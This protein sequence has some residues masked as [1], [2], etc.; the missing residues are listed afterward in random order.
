MKRHACRDAWAKRTRVPV[1]VP[2]CA[3][4]FA[5]GGCQRSRAA[6]NLPSIALIRLIQKRYRACAAFSHLTPAGGAWARP[7]TAPM[8][9]GHCFGG[10]SRRPIGALPYFL[11]AQGFFAAHGFFA[12]QGFALV[13]ALFLAEQ[14]LQPANATAGM[15]STAPIRPADRIAERTRV[16][17]GFFMVLLLG[18]NGRTGMATPCVD[19][20]LDG[21]RARILTLV[22]K[23]IAVPPVSSDAGA[24]VR[25]AEH[26]SP[27][28]MFVAKPERP[29]IVAPVCHGARCSRTRCSSLEQVSRFEAATSCRVQAPTCRGACVPWSRR[30]AASDESLR[31]RAAR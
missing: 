19:I 16:G 11:A 25:R 5:F 8:T 24:M 10:T 15:P 7:R 12:A 30:A 9:T 2:P 1:T 21:P 13:P 26:R 14:G 28:A 3:R 22:V 23:R 29:R 27:C 18:V 4:A 17:R 6:T 20:P 31:P